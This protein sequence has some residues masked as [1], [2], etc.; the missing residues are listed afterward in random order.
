MMNMKENKLKKSLKSGHSVFGTW[1]MLSSPQVINVIGY[2]GMDFVIIDLEHGP[3]NFE[4]VEYQLYAAE[5]AGIIPIV[6]VADSSDVNV[7]RT[8]EIGTQNLLV[9][10]VSTPEEA[11]QVV[12][13]CKYPPKGDRGLSP[14][15]R[16]HGYSE[17]NLVEKLQYANDQMFV[18]VLVEG[19][20]G[21]KNLERICETPNL[22]MVYLGVYDISMSLGI[23]GDLYNSKVI[24]F[25]KDC[26]KI[27]ESKGLCAGSVARDKEYI[28]IMYEAGFNFISYRADS[29]VLREGF[30]QATGWYQELIDENKQ[31]AKE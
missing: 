29:P 9:S 28:R 11:V 20:N 26:V 12:R 7:L 14:F 5:T 31:F 18:G 30:A 24:K 6:R 25:I 8:L 23:P 15:T 10:H 3:T 16:N 1:S 21:L 13:A 17:E 2:S 27:I 4:T 22:D 19:E